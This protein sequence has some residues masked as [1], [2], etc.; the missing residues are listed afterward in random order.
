[1]NDTGELKQWMTENIQCELR[2]IKRE[3]ERMNQHIRWVEP[4]LEKIEM[5]LQIITPFFKLNEKEQKP[6]PKSNK[7]VAD[8]FDK[9]V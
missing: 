6:N 8:Y 9:I 7:N 1:M 5:I 3:I 2:D 4:I